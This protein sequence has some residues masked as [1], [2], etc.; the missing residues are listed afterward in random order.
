VKINVQRAKAQFQKYQTLYAN[1]APGGGMHPVCA[2]VC[3][4]LLEWQEARGIRGDLLEIG[5][6]FGNGAGLLNQHRR[7]DERLILVDL[8]KSQERFLANVAK[9]NALPTESLVFYPGNSLAMRRRD[10]LA[11]HRDSCRFLHIDGEHSFEAVV[12]DLDLCA[13]LISERGILAVDDVFTAA[14]P[15]VTEALYYWLGRNREKLVM[16][17][18]GYQ[19]AYLC[20]ARILPELMELIYELPII[21]G[22]WGP[23]V[24][25]CASG[26]VNDRPSYGLVPFVGGTHQRINRVLPTP[27]FNEMM[28]GPPIG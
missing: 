21:I 18:V 2:A 4:L 26:W 14:S 16:F 12:S 19:K 3:S 28:F 15:C 20:S 8:N 27:S 23:Q 11:R 13:D 6:W 1:P 5:V 17:L 9:G 10:A 22:G 25:L 24:S 7:E